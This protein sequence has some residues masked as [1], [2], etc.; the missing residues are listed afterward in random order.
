MVKSFLL[1]T[2][3]HPWQIE[4]N[5][6]YDLLSSQYPFVNYQRYYKSD[7]RFYQQKILVSLVQSSLYSWTLYLEYDLTLFTLD[8][9]FTQIPNLEF[10]KE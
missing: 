5:I 8:N 7:R 1:A 9:H 6:W 10:Y 4:A 2:S 3:N